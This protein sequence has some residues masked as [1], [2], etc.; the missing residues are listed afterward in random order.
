[1][2]LGDFAIA[3]AGKIDPFA[4]LYPVARGRDF[5]SIGGHLHWPRVG[6]AE[7]DLGRRWQVFLV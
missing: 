2:E 5:W 6:A 1:M 3:D 4:P 7:L